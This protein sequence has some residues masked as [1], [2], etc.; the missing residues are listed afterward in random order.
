MAWMEL[1]PC[2]YPS[3]E[4]TWHISA[5]AISEVR[6]PYARLT[7]LFHLRRP[8][9]PPMLV[10]GALSPPVREDAGLHRT[11]AAEAWDAGGD[12]HPVV[13][14]TLCCAPPRLLG[15]PRLLQESSKLPRSLSPTCRWALPGV[16]PRAPPCACLLSTRSLLSLTVA[17]R[18]SFSLPRLTLTTVS[19]AW[20]SASALTASFVKIACHLKG[21]AANR[22]SL[23]SR[24]L[25]HTT[26]TKDRL[27]RNRVASCRPKG[28]FDCFLSE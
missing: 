6:L 1:P 11:L 12:S 2:A 17:T 22:L 19:W 24:T 14:H 20:A 7:I 21:S 28:A 25:P 27:N 5:F 10:F 13:T 15:S 9:V 8:P 4:L 16:L 26:Q 18:L 3:H 23:T